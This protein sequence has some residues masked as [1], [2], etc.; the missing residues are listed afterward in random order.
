MHFSV[1][2]IVK[3]LP[4]ILSW[5]A[6][7]FTSF[8]SMEV[9]MVYASSIHGYWCAFKTASLCQAASTCSLSA[10][11]YCILA[12]L[13]VRETICTV[14]FTSLYLFCS[15]RT[16]VSR[17]SMFE[18]SC[19]V[20]RTSNDYSNNFVQSII[21]LL[22]TAIDVVIIVVHCSLTYGRVEGCAFNYS[23]STWR[24]ISSWALAISPL[25][26]VRTPNWPLLT[27]HFCYNITFFSL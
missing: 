7:S 8:A 27:L 24:F 10:F 13:Y 25:M 14:P 12:S 9:V 6:C 15:S 26:S 23:F 2:S 5:V 21:A 4:W 16:S 17:C 18:S 11:T 1:T 19:R 3:L 22:T 20:V